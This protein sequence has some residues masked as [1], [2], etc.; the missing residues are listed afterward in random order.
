M[1]E[2]S[3]HDSGDS[4]IS[5]NGMDETYVPDETMTSDEEQQSDAILKTLLQR[6]RQKPDKY[7]FWCTEECNEYFSNELTLK[8]ALQGPEKKQWEQAVTEELKSFEDNNAW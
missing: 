6:Q 8:E 2:L 7:G 5:T 1:G 3:N 4:F